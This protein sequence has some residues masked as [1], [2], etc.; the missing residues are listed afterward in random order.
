MLSIRH[1]IACA[2]VLILFF[3]ASGTSVWA[4]APGSSSAGR[5][6]SLAVQQDPFAE[7]DTI[8]RFALGPVVELKFRGGIGDFADGRSIGLSNG[9]TFGARAE[10][11]LN[12]TVTFVVRGSY[13]RTEEKVEVGTGDATFAGETAHIEAAGELLLKGKASVPGYFIFGGGVRFVNPD[14]VVAGDATT[15]RFTKEESTTESLIIAGVG[16][17]LGGRRRGVFRIEGRFTF[18]FPTEQVKFDTKSVATDFAL[19]LAYLFRF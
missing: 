16:L 2:V 12:R 5:A 13:A 9:P 7:P 10:L 4:Q 18:S 17:E 6:G 15:A 8:P 14:A 19:G 11:R 3:S 1:G